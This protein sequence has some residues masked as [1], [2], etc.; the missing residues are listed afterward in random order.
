MTLLMLM[1]MVIYFLI[2]VNVSISLL[3]FCLNTVC[4]LAEWTQRM[5]PP[6]LRVIILE[7]NKRGWVGPNFNFSGYPIV[8]VSNL[9]KPTRK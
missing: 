9:V 6:Q 4:L 1:L 7:I 5:S 8:D 2:Y 3:L